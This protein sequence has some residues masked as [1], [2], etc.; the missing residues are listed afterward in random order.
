[1]DELKGIL[2]DGEVVLWSGQPDASLTRPLAPYWRRKLVHFFWVFLFACI[3][4]ILLQIESSVDRTGMIDNVAM[5]LGIIVLIGVL[6]GAVTFFDFKDSAVPHQ[7][8][9]YAITDR[10]L[11]SL[12]LNTGLRQSAFA[13]S[14]CYVAY[15]EN[16]RDSTLSVHIGYGEDDC[17]LLRGLPD[18]KNVEKMIVEQFS[19]KEEK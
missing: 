19:I 9:V 12:N 5:V 14:V 11:I 10:R 18:A 8:D 17:L 15:N 3:F 2:L 1:M 6:F 16:H 7:C 4:L 13:N